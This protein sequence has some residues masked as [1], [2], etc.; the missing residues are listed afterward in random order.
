MPTT[1]APYRILHARDSV[2]AL[3]PDTIKP[4]DMKTETQPMTITLPPEVR[5]RLQVIAAA[6]GST[7]EETVRNIS[8]M[9]IQ[10]LRTGEM[11]DAREVTHEN[12]GKGEHA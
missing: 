10:F 8:V 7:E 6:T 9:M 4:R 2:N 1:H 12:D 5:H 3:E 11:P